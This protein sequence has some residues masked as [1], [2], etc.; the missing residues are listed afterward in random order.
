MSNTF[1][2][3]G[4]PRSMTA[5]L[6]NFLTTGQSHCF[7]DVFTMCHPKTAYAGDLL[8]SI[9]LEYVGASGSDLPFFISQIEAS[10]PNARHVLIERNPADVKKSLEALYDADM[11]AFMD[12]AAVKIA[13]YAARFNPL[14]VRFADISTLEGIGKIWSHCLPNKRFDHDRWQMLR[15]FNIQIDEKRR[16]ELRIELR[17]QLWQQS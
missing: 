13:K 17:R 11:S 2:I 15:H 8:A 16:I 4:Y 3:A 12:I 1:F 7:H 14:L 9:P 5:W 6:A 10:F